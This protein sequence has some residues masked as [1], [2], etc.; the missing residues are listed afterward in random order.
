MGRAL[1]LSADDERQWDG[2]ADALALEGRRG[3]AFVVSDSAEVRAEIRDRLRDEAPALVHLTPSEDIYRQ[4]LAFTRDAARRPEPPLP[5]VW[6]EADTEDPAELARCWG[7]ALFV[8]NTKRDHLDLDGPLFLVLA[9]PFAAL[10]HFRRAPDLRSVTGPMLQ[11]GVETSALMDL[12]RPLC[13]LHLSDLHVHDLL[14]D[15][16]LVL[17]A[18]LCDLPKLARDVGWS[19]D[20]VFLTGDIS[21]RGAP[22]ELE[23]AHRFLAALLEALGL[24]APQ[25]L[26]LVP[27]NHDVDRGRIRRM[28]KGDQEQL[29]ALGDPDKLRE[30]L[31]A[32]QGDPR[33]MGDYGERLLAFCEFSGKLLG[34]AR[35]VSPDRPWRTDI[36]EVGG[37]RVG[38]A[39]LCSAWAC[40]PDEDRK[41]RILLGE[42][43]ARELLDEL[44]GVHLRVALM[45][46]PPEWLHE[47]EA[48]AA[49]LLHDRFHL[50]LH[51]HTH[52]AGLYARA[53]P[54][55][56][57]L[58]A[59]A[60][61]VYAGGRWPKGFQ[62]GRWDPTRGE[63]ELRFFGYTDRQGGYW[64]PDPG[65]MRPGPDGRVVLPLQVESVARSDEQPQQ[66]EALARRIARA[67]RG[68]FS[69]L[70]FLGVP[71]DTATKPRSGLT[72]VFVPLDLEED[73][74]KG[75]R[76]SLEALEA[77]LF[78][79]RKAGRAVVLGDPGSGKT[80]LLRWLAL[81]CEAHGRA[82]LLLALR[83]WLRE[84]QRK[85][86]MEFALGE[87]SG[88]LQV[89]VD[90][91][92]LEALCK[93]GQALLLIDGLDEVAD[94]SQ[95]VWV[96][97]AVA[98]LA[99]RFPALPILTSS[100]V[101]GYADCPLDERG[102]RHL[103]LSPFDDE[104]LAEFVQRWTEATEPDPVQRAERRQ[105]L[106][107]AL[108]AEPR[109]KHL[110]RNPLFA[111]LIA[112]VHQSEAALPGERAQLYELL[113]RMMLETR[114][115]A[116]HQRFHHD[117]LDE[118]RQRGAL[119]RLALR[120][121]EGRTG[122]E[123]GDIT[124]SRAELEGALTELLSA[125][126]L[127]GE[128][129]ASVESV[130][131]RWV[132]WLAARTGLLVE[133]RPGVFGFL[134]LSVME[135]LAGRA[136]YERLSAGGDAAVARF[137]VEKHR[138]GHWRE[139][140]L[141]MLGKEARR[142]G[143]VEAVTEALLEDL[144]GRP[145]RAFVTVYF[146]LWLVREEVDLS[147][148]TLGQ[149]LNWAAVLVLA[150]WPGWWESARKLLYDILCFGRRNGRPVRAWLDERLLTGEGDALLGAVVLAP[151]ASVYPVPGPLGE[152]PD[153]RQASSVLLELWPIDDWG[154]WAAAELSPGALL[155]WARTLS[156]RLA[157]W[158]CLG[159]QGTG[160]ACGAS[161]FTLTLLLRTQWSGN[162]IARSTI[163]CASGT[164]IPGM[165]GW[166]G[167]DL[168]AAY[169]PRTM[170]RV[171]GL[172]ERSHDGLVARQVSSLFS[173]HFADNI[174]HDLSWSFEGDMARSFVTDFA[175]AFAS[176]DVTHLASY[177][178]S[179]WLAG[180][181]D[182]W[183]VYFGK[184]WVHGL[185]V[186]MVKILVDRY[187][188][189]FSPD[190]GLQLTNELSDAL[191]GS[192]SLP[193][194]SLQNWNP[195]LPWARLA[196]STDEVHTRS[197]VA[198]ILASMIADAYAGLLPLLDPTDPDRVQRAALLATLR[199]Q[200][201]WL[202]LFFDPLA[203][204]VRSKHP[205]TPEQHALLLALG[206]AQFQTTWQWPWGEQWAQLT[207]E[208][209]PA[210]W[211]PR[212]FWHQV[213]AVST[214]D[215][216]ATDAALAEAERALD[217]AD[218]PELA[219]ALREH[220]LIPTPQEILDLFDP[221]P[222]APPSPAPS[223]ST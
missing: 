142:R 117:R 112:L 26:F 44:S 176:D 37:L 71:A 22:R 73:R 174:A 84:A 20:L 159:S 124:L 34:A 59:A 97:D 82:P 223:G 200:N 69:Q 192:R 143:L 150:T 89:A 118:G 189:H 184:V 9:G 120:M 77:L 193:F 177:C 126:E 213:R 29:L 4:I 27:G 181:A 139:T 15:Q 152:R 145:S 133:Q 158:Y 195:S 76:L 132:S 36:R 91:S 38:V 144:R 93:T 2:L 196:S 87:L 12:K 146:L 35:A 3:V 141:L 61:A 52:D 153:Y 94:P 92:Q 74:S 169:A 42:R 148:E 13:W 136:L 115:Q 46:H 172:S 197:A 109:A 194:S 179:E 122:K 99:T 215:P 216:V 105:G 81:R 214:R 72:D 65:V 185:A 6:V 67:A 31:A 100:R 102:W 219:N 209:A 39:S 162:V 131:R 160:W 80:T 19:P 212:F 50:L 18:L 43:Q 161:T 7:P 138:E 175:R 130:V 101:N 137:V 90:R 75:E 168:Q 111:T 21:D 178:V 114:P 218:W 129:R 188:H 156:P 48:R 16:D 204:H 166:D 222:E 17:K 107:S 25:H 5:V 157:F 121:Q 45:H 221:G 86:L 58:V 60:G 68:V 187:A 103:R 180:A 70:N 167:L 54:S 11:L 10:E 49:E 149:V 217:A 53:T 198:R 123:Q 79:P 165:L 206:L 186:S 208:P 183:N 62:L 190:L 64:H 51:G 211:L 220:I 104:K 1:A 134:H 28:V 147:A 85:D 182:D 66:Q 55:S 33:E 151:R 128:G 207:A 78:D 155:S 164:R 47:A 119:E 98:G 57:G 125:R 173:L 41:G 106:M 203:A 135:Y 201:R 113:V 199:L 24:N 95:R 205:S 202:Y 163:A 88:R 32:R 23:A 210:H 14:W 108:D 63:V 127:A 56:R 40:G 8:L 96:C 154:S 171:A 170:T 116:T 30:E 83:D 140:L 110:A 191:G